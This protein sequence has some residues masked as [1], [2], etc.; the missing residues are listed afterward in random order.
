[1]LEMCSSFYMYASRS[2]LGVK[3]SPLVDR[4]VCVHGLSDVAA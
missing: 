4:P 2:F 3:V 1:M